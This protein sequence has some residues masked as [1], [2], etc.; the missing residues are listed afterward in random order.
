MRPALASLARKTATK[1]YI[2]DTFRSSVGR[3]ERG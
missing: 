3:D 2:L 1:M